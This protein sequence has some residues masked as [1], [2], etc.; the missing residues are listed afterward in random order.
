MTQGAAACITAHGP[1][2]VQSLLFTLFLWR[3]ASVANHAAADRLG[4]AFRTAEEARLLGDSGATNSDVAVEMDA[5]QN[6]LMD[7]E[8]RINA[9]LEHAKADLATLSH[10]QSAAQEVCCYTL[11]YIWADMLF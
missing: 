7:A 8:Q 9:E 6:P 1:P 2:D 4:Q 3:R 11:S 10:L 5:Y